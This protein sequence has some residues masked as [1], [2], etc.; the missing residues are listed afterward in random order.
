[1]TV[2][3]RKV[4]VTHAGKVKVELCRDGGRRGYLYAAEYRT[5]TG[6]LVC[7]NYFVGD[8]QLGCGMDSLM[9]HVERTLLRNL[10]NA[11]FEEV[12]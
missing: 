6:Q 3:M 1:M 10:A 4:V 12:A 2:L 9:L 8:E 11:A 7:S 5:A